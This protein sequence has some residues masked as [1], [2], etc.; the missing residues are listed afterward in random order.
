MPLCQICRAE[1]T[2]AERRLCRKCEAILTG[3]APPPRTPSL[4]PRK[5]SSEPE[6][7]IR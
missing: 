7:V 1:L 5:P 2:L 3:E 4:P 6:P